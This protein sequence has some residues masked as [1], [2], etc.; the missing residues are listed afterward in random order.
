MLRKYFA[1]TL[2]V[3]FLASVSSCKKAS[4]AKNE[5]EHEAINRVE[6]IFKQAGNTVATIV[7]EDPDG[8]GGNPPS[9]I[10]P[11]NLQVNQTYDVEVKFFNIV[12]GSTK[13]VTSTVQQQ[14]KEHEVYFILSGF[15]FPI[16]KKDFDVNGFPLGLISQWKTGAVS[17]QGSVLLKLMHKPLIKG[18]NDDPSKGHSD[19]AVNFPLKVN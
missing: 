17:A 5:T 16:E 9:K 15:N 12:N 10:D 1:L 19:I 13:E 7:A 6:L 2:F 4:M 8:D 18:P 14:A 11:I 3:A